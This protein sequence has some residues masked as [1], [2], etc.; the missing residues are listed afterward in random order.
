LAQG[1]RLAKSVTSKVGTP[2]LPAGEILVKASIDLLKKWKITRVAIEGPG[3]AN[4]AAILNGTPTPPEDVM[5]M[6]RETTLRRFS[7]VDIN[8]ACAAEL[9]EI[10]VERQER[11]ILGSPGQTHNDNAAAPAPAFH[12]P[13]PKPV[14]M[15]GVLASKFILGTLPLVFHRLAEIINNPYSST[16]DIAQVVSA[17]PAM[18]AKLLRMANSP[19]Y[20]LLSKVDTIP[21][22]VALVGTGQIIMLALGA[23]LITAFKG[24]P[25]S[26]I[27]MQSFWNHSISCG[28]AARQLALYAGIGQPD[29]YFVAGLLHDVARLLIYTQLPTH[30]LYLLT[31]AKRQRVSVHSLEESVLSFTHE[32]LGGQ[33]LN[34]WRCPQYLIQQVREHHSPLPETPLPEQAVL[35]LADTL[36]HAMGMGTSGE[37]LVPSPDKRAWAALNLTPLHL[38]E[39]CQKMEGQVREMR[40][41]LTPDEL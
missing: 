33:L 17:D 6:A 14:G 2:L 21:R 34:N 40:A 39:I 8:D 1:D 24:M 29:G 22:A 32:T 5:Q 25:V 7:L 35:P 20:G 18:V 28:V 10:A 9:F 11:T 16:S 4:H 12:M 3:T 41:L 36:A 38:R 19:F 26:L 31:E 15:G 30:A 27:T 23:T 37:T 13:M